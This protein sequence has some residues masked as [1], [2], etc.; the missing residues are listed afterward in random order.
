MSGQIFWSI[1]AFSELSVTELYDIFRLRMEVFVVEQNCPYQDADGKDQYASHLMGRNV[2]EELIAY[3]RIFPCG[4][5]FDEVS[6]GRVI[7]SGKARSTGAGKMLM[8]KAITLSRLI[9]GNQPVRI[10]AQSY[11]I[12]FYKSF[13]FE[14]VS[15][16]YLEDNIPHVEML[17]PAEVS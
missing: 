13:G 12:K 7:T 2:D 16:E 6:I 10:G 8:E 17:K 1:K 5:T 15:E 4:I 11:L 3:A 9:Y 14:V